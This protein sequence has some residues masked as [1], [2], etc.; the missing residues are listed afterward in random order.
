M[1]GT[2]RQEGIDVA[3]L[4]VF[5]LLVFCCL[6]VFFIAVRIEILNYRVGSY[7]P[8]QKI[9]AGAY[10]KWRTT[11]LKMVRLN[12]ARNYKERE[13]SLNREFTAAEKQELERDLL[14]REAETQSWNSLRDL[15]AT[16]GMLQYLLIPV[17]FYFVILSIVHQEH[18]FHAWKAI[19]YG[20]L[21]L[22]FYSVAMAVYRA[23]YTVYLG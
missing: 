23:Y 19:L 12:W 16:L 11:S 3:K 10:P 21:I 14:K 4:N 5:M 7:L 15:C 1:E 17:C 18:G 22:L 2:D 20:T 13:Q 8:R 6:F 9:K